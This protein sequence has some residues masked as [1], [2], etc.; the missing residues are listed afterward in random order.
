MRSHRL[1][2]HTMWSAIAVH[3]L[4]DAAQQSPGGVEAHLRGLTV[5][6]LFRFEEL[7]PEFGGPYAYLAHPAALAVTI[8]RPIDTDPSQ[9]WKELSGSDNLLSNARGDVWVQPAMGEPLRNVTHGATDNS[10]WFS[11]QWSPDGV[12]LAMLSTRGGELRL[13]TWNRLTGQLSLVSRDEVTFS[14]VQ[15]NVGHDQP[16]VWVDSRNILCTVLPATPTQKLTMAYAYMESETPALATSAWHRYLSGTQSTASTLDDVKN[17]TLPPGGNLVLVD[18]DGHQETLARNVDTLLW[19]PSPSGSAVAFTRQTEASTEPGGYLQALVA[20]GGEW[21]AEVVTSDGRKV[22]ATGDKASDVMPSSLRWSPDGLTLAYLGYAS[23]SQAAPGLYFLD[24]RTDGVRAVALRGLNASPWGG[25]HPDPVDGYEPPALE[26][27]ATGK[28][29]VRAARVAATPADGSQRSDREDWWL[30]SR[31]GARR[32]LT[33]RLRTVAP[34]SLWPEWG[35]RRFFGVASRKLWEVDVSSGSVNE[36][37]A[38]MHLSVKEL[39]SPAPMPVLYFVDSSRTLAHRTYGHAVFSADG[40]GGPKW[41]LFDIRS[42]AITPL[43]PPAPRAKLVSVAPG[44]KSFLF[45]RSDRSGLSLWRCDV[46]CDMSE[47][48]L[49]AN[50]FLRGIAEARVVHFPYTSLDGA[51]LNAWLLLPLGYRADRRYPMITFV[52]PTYN[53]PARP[54]PWEISYFAGTSSESVFNMEIAAAHGYAV[55]FPSIPIPYQSRD[56]L[57]IRVIR[58]V[59]PAVDAAVR[60]GFADPDRVAAW[61]MSYGGDA[62]YALIGRTDRFRAGIVSS[63]A[64][65]LISAYGALDAR[66]RYSE[67]AQEEVGLESIIESGEA[68]LGGPPWKHWL[69]YIDNSPIF[70]VNRIRTPLLITAGDLDFVPI[71]QAEECF[72]ALVRQDRPVR[73]VRYWGEGHRLTNPANIRDYWR[74]IFRWLHRYLVLPR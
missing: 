19:Q 33:C 36:L 52:Y 41:Y 73:F 23:K 25:H 57:A 6:D 34:Q 46:H 47:L 70:S 11:P 18:L 40:H 12:H 29:L 20:N 53:F 66:V 51:K 9:R 55:L 39:V 7:G 14:L 28:V 67:W 44:G 24:M 3:C 62:V 15:R 72:R 17:P 1:L 58:E 10:G 65:D 69:R 64:C 22:V 48:L 74:Q 63:T 31:D 4:A 43:T 5:N 59:L 60:R 38:H 8:L 54:V 37:T 2:V 16:Y 35:R 61:G 26:W 30:V 68:N 56:E 21:R 42:R 45:F 32:C 50:T 27:T 49:S 71:Q 13:W